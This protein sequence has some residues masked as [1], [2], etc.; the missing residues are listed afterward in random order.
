MRQR[1]EWRINRKQMKINIKPGSE[2]ERRRDWKQVSGVMRHS[3]GGGEDVWWW[4]E[5]WC[6]TSS[7]ATNCPLGKDHSFLQPST[8]LSAFTSPIVK[9]GRR[10]ISASVVISSRKWNLKRHLYS[11]CCIFFFFKGKPFQGYKTLDTPQSPNVHTSLYIWKDIYTSICLSPSLQVVVS[12]TMIFALLIFYTTV[13][14]VLVS[15][16]QDLICW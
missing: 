16:W 1:V 5:G 6:V 7:T 2:G 13:F 3:R 9:Q 8:T 12:R 10:K 4:V 15:F 11:L 14:P